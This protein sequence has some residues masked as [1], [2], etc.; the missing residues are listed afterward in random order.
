MWF[1][2][3]RSV[4]GGRSRGFKRCPGGRALPCGLLTL[5]GSFGEAE[6]SDDR[7]FLEAIREVWWRGPWN[8]QRYAPC[9]IPDDRATGGGDTSQP[10]VDADGWGV[11]YI[12]SLGMWLLHRVLG[13]PGSGV[14][15]RKASA[16]VCTRN[17]PY[18]C[19]PVPR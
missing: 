9:G 17:S 11:R 15:A 18:P 3:P 4:S 13:N 16:S 1:L 14:D 10:L 6:T 19:C 8:F 7:R 5:V 12:P 2:P